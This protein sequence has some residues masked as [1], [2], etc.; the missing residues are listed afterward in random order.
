[1]NKMNYRVAK[2]Y[3]SLYV[4]FEYGYAV[5]GAIVVYD[6]DEHNYR[7]NICKDTKCLH[8]K[9]V[10]TDEI[11]KIENTNFRGF[12]RHTISEAWKRTEDGK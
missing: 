6:P 2:V 1:M 5:D 4:V 7:C 10:I 8:I 12:A 11:D 3:D 9:E